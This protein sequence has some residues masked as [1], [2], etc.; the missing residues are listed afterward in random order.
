ML[1]LNLL[2]SNL[3]K[4][5]NYQNSLGIVLLFLFSNVNRENAQLRTTNGTGTAQQYDY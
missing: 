3:H 4:F 2:S 1:S 5:R